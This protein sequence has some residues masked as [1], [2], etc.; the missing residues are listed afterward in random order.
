MHTG[1][2]GGQTSVAGF[3]A[4]ADDQALRLQ[5]LAHLTAQLGSAETLGSI[6][7]IVVTHAGEVIRAAVATLMLRDDDRL[8]LVGAHGVQPGIEDRFASFGLL[9]ENPA[10]EAAR[11][12]QPVVLSANDNI[13]GR[14]P[15]LAGTM[16]AGRS[17]VC[18]PLRSTAQPLGVIGL[19]FEASWVPGARELDFL[20][21]FADSCAQAIRRVR[22][23]EQ[24]QRTAR[25]LTFLADA[26][27]E[28]ASSLNYPVTLAHVARLS[29][30]TLADWCAVSM[31]GSGGALSTLAVAHVD[32]AKVESAWELEKRYPPDP[33]APTGVPNVVRTGQSEL[34]REITD[35]ML[36]AGARDEEHLRLSRDLDLRSALVVPLTARGR[37]LGAITLLRTTGS[38]E[39][40][41]AELAVAEDLGRRAGVAIDNSRLHSET[42]DIARQLQR[43]VLP[44][45]LAKLTQWQIATH[46]RPGGRAEVGGDFYDAI[47]LGEG[48]LAIFIGD[49]MGHGVAAA[50]AMGQMRSA[51]R[52]YLCIDPAP[53]AIVK[54]LDGMFARLSIDQLT[55]LAYAVIDT[56]TG[57]VRIVSAGHYPPMI[58]S[59]D[60]APRLAQT[61]PRRPLGAGGDERV[62]SAWPLEPGD[63][64][65]LYT[66]GLVERRNEVI[67][68]GL[69]R[70]IDHAHVLNRDSLED[71]LRT[72]VA[73]LHD[74]AGDDDVTAIAVRVDMSTRSRLDDT[75]RP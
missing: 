5:Q 20:T 38:D 3:V 47:P 11:T 39:Y 53:S 70:L 71:G 30:P 61:A 12:G 36:V 56:A 29:V 55:S 19:T 64:I 69:A 13:E 67:D 34:Y 54:A 35:D 57:E 22:A 31:V 60:G 21:T 52:A 48:L 41:P 4:P 72:L 40:G 45:D 2:A 58:V 42:Q 63:T 49:V 37:T 15:A 18:L 24:A 26:S 66:D 44:D 65:L 16:P 25:Q 32:P 62:E 43:A 46:Y 17:L 28:L 8:E 14:Y 27:A 68:V 33:D 75:A 51:I 50:A 74:D 59:R 10:S 9:D 7:N 73:R 1:P 6:I 23:T